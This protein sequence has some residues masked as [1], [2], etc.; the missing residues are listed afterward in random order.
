MRLTNLSRQW[1]AILMGMLLLVAGCAVAPAQAQGRAA[2]QNAA[3]NAATTYQPQTRVFT[4]TSVPL[5]VHEMQ[6][7]MDFLKKDFAKGGLLDG[8]EVYGFYPSTLVVYAGDTVKLSLVNPQ[9]DPHTFTIP[10]LGVNANMPAQSK[11]D[12]TFVASKAGV[13]QFICAE[14]EHS[15]YMWGQMIVLPAPTAQ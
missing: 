3:T 14:P 12:A 15:P 7:S 13:Y 4:V 9:D 11:T 5:A 8:K 6:D 10:D 2:T 1:F